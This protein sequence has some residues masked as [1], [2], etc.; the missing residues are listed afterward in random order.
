VPRALPF[1]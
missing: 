1:R